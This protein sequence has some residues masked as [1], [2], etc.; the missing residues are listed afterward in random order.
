MSPKRLI[1]I[2]EKDW[3]TIASRVIHR[4]HSDPQVPNY[5]ALTDHE[6]RSR[7]R[8]LLS[9]LGRWLGRRDEASLIPVVLPWKLDKSEC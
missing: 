4:V 6:L 1:E 3:K 8:D 5:Q 7:A 9:Q 2:V